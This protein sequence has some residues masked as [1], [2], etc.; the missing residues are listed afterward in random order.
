MVRTIEKGKTTG[1]GNATSGGFRTL[2]CV[3]TR[4]KRKLDGQIDACAVMAQ[5][6]AGQYGRN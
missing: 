4:I 2:E 6:Q 5:A 3:K 1:H